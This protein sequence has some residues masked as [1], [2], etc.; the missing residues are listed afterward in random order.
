MNKISGISTHLKNQKG[1]VEFVT[2]PIIFK[3]T[4]GT[5]TMNATI[6]VKK[7]T[8]LLFEN[9]KKEKKDT[10]TINKYS[11]NDVDDKTISYDFS[12]IDQHL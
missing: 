3:K 6:V 11:N 5:G 8:C 10:E 12:I 2:V 7:V 9:N 4:A 1:N